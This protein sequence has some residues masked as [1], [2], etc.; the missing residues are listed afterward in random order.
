M[1][2]ELTPGDPAPSFS[3]ERD[4][5]GTMTLDDFKGQLLVLYFYPK[6]GTSGCT[7][8]AQAFSGMQPAFRSA[9]VSVVGVSPDPVRAL[10]KFRDKY[11]LKIPLLSDPIHET[12]EAYGV[13]TQKSMY[14]RKYMGVERS[15]FLIGPDGRVRRT[16]RKVKV[17]GH[18]D[19]V[20]AAAQ[21]EPA[22]HG[23]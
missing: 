9:G 20:L 2:P 18:V 15:T 10:D 7:L 17:P 1:Q 14:G 23:G 13:W 22:T 8:E 11:G 5:G 3:L 4:G 6:A 19:D 21:A 16:W 12:L